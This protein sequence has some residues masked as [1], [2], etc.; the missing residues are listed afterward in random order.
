M[1]Q[2]VT[3]QL[4]LDVGGEEANMDWQTEQQKLVFHFWERGVPVS[5]FPTSLVPTRGG[6]SHE[7]RHLRVGDVIKNKDCRWDVIT[8]IDGGVK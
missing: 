6:K 4:G 8:R 3:E 5:W 1:W 2:T 7:A